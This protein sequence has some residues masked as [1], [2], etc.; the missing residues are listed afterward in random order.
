MGM[1][2]RF[3]AQIRQHLPGGS[4]RHAPVGYLVDDQHRRQAARAHAGD[5]LEGKA[6]IVGGLVHGDAKLGAEVGE[7]G[8]GVVHMTGSAPADANLMFAGRMKAKEVVEG[9]HAEDT[10]QRKTKLPGHVLEVIAPQVAVVALNLLEHGD[11]RVRFPPVVVED[12]G[13]FSWRRLGQRVTAIDMFAQG[14]LGLGRHCRLLSGL[15]CDSTA[16]AWGRALL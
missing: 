13:Q 8:L 10:R 16:N 2:D 4:G 7:D 12:D 3:L 6:A 14:R 11:E 9:R 5:G 1:L 15:W